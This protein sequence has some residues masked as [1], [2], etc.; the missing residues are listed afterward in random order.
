MSYAGTS[1]RLGA[2]GRM[3]EHVGV[4]ERSGV[5][6]HY[7]HVQCS[8]VGGG[9]RASLTRSCAGDAID[10]CSM[11][12]DSKGRRNDLIE[13]MLAIV[14]KNARAGLRR[15]DSSPKYDRLKPCPSSR[16]GRWESLCE[17]KLC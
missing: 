16:S 6:L 2:V 5:R 12:Y 13:R 14:D 3:L 1:S 4:V 15:C 11:R 8:R 10:L 7:W 17:D 9:S